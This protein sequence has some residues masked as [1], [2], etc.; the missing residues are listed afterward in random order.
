ML[1]NN[2]KALEELDRMVVKH[3]LKLER[4][5]ATDYTRS[6]DFAHSVLQTA[7]VSAQP[8]LCSDCRKNQQHFEIEL[9]QMIVPQYKINGWKAIVRRVCIPCQNVDDEIFEC[10]P[11]LPIA[12]VLAALR[13][14]GVT[15]R[16]LT[17]ITK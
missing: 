1:Q 12:M 6:A 13:M 8:P 9:T 17:E 14:A 16:E 10:G 5:H 7:V 15:Q 11:T 4:D 3:V 2:L